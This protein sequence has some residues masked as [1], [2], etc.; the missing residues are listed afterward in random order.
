MPVLNV[1]IVFGDCE[2]VNAGLCFGSENIFMRE[3]E[4][5]DF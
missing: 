1:W 2:F 5:Q 3:N 4:T